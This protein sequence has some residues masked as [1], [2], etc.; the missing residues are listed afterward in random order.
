MTAWKRIQTVIRR[1]V[2]QIL[3]EAISR[4]TIELV[5]KLYIPRQPH[6]FQVCYHLL[7]LVQITSN[8]AE[9]T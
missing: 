1:L 6:F 4:T 7:R 8:I 5:L 9:N 3:A 2:G